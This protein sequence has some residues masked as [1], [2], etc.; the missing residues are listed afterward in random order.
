[1]NT[2]SGI[3]VNTPPSYQESLWG[4]AKSCA[5]N[6]F[7]KKCRNEP[8]SIACTDCRWNVQRYSP[9]DNRSVEL[10]MIKAESMARLQMNMMR[11]WS[12]YS[13]WTDVQWYGLWTIIIGVIVLLVLWFKGII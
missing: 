9:I 13:F 10:L 12:W 7:K 4:V 3:N 5:Y 2:P 1:M 11:E 8:C 6:R